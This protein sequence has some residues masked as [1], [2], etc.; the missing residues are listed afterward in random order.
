MLSWRCKVILKT[1]IAMELSGT[2][3]QALEQVKR[4]TPIT[5]TKASYLAS[6]VRLQKA[7]NTVAGLII[8]DTAEISQ[9]AM[10]KFLSE[11]K[12]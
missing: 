10:N 8:T 1:G 5:E 7:S 6:Q 9:K 4:T 12:G 3:V 11:A 2:N